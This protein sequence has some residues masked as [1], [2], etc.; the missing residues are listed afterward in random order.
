MEPLDQLWSVDEA[1]YTAKQQGKNRNTAL[2][3]VS[4]YKLNSAGF[5]DIFSHKKKPV[6]LFCDDLHNHRSDIP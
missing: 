1:L 4:F 2:E 5:I 3:M 6:S